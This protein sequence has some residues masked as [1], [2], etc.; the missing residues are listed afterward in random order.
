MNGNGGHATGLGARALGGLGWAYLGTFCKSLLS[1]LAL[2]VLARLLTPVDYGLLGI[3]WIFIVLGARFGQAVVG[4]A[5][6]QREDLTSRHIQVG[7]TLSLA[8]GAA[9][10]AAV[11]LL[12]PVIAAFFNEPALLQVVQVL[13][14]IFLINGVSV[15]PVSLLRRQLDFKRLSLADVLAYLVGYGCT[16]VALASQGFGVWSLVWGEIMHKVV[17]ALA[18]IGSSGPALRPR[19]SQQEAADL[20]SRGVGFSLAR[21]FEFIAR[22][23]GHFVIGRWLGAAALG[24]YTRADRLILLPRNYVSQNLFQV[25]F[26][27]MAR[28]QQGT[29]RLATVYRHGL[30]ALALVAVP[31]GALVF[32]AAPEIVA[33]ILGAQWEPVTLLLR[34]L[35]F[36]ILFQVCDVLNLAVAGAVG[37]VYRQAWRQG[38]HAVLVVGGAWFASRWGLREVVVVLVGA[39]II[40]YLLMTQ[41]TVSLLEVRRWA[42]LRCYLPAL[43]T[44]AWAAVALWLTAGQLRAMALPAG[45][46]LFVEIAVWFTASLAALYYAP[47][48]ARALCIPWAVKNVSFEVL[49]APGKCLRRGLD[50]LARGKG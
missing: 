27:A 16:A 49:G 24:Y 42:L 2:V 30:E 39:Q 40:A 7:F 38:L 20:L 47:P 43:W 45:V 14:L 37:A 18:V 36:A 3:A 22:M 6:V 31:V 17:Y 25:L 32:A 50:W 28:R 35:A 5:L 12:A 1:L 26:P 48:F 19:W 33:V 10:A 41:L 8:V 44:G 13:A 9:L 4:P 11:W 46:A 34:I 15:V 23:G 29:E 21:V